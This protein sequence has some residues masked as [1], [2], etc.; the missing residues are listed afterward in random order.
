MLIDLN[1]KCRLFIG[2]YGIS[3]VSFNYG[4]KVTL[5]TLDAR[6]LYFGPKMIFIFPPLL[7]MIFCSP[8]ATRFF[9]SH[10]GLFA[11]ILPY[12]A[13]IL[14]FYFPFSHIFPHSSFFF[15]SSSFF[16]YIFPLFLFAFSY[17]FPQMTSADISPP[18]PQGGE[19]F[20][21]YRPLLDAKSQKCPFI[22]SLL[23]VS[24]ARKKLTQCESIGLT[25]VLGR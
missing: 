7:K 11:L 1:A 12:F 25:T 9:Y 19:Y 14:P 15:P 5:C 4:C 18:S 21:I 10:R 24:E 23:G 20:P 2:K 16:F 17:F 22:N 6:G 8:L 3:T 13:S